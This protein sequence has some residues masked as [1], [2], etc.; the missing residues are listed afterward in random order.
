MQLL[1]VWVIRESPKPDV[2][3]ADQNRREWLGRQARLAIYRPVAGDVA[4]G[5]AGQSSACSLTLVQVSPPQRNPITHPST[6]RLVDDSN[7]TLAL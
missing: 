4:G 7:F 2:P 3:Q 1:S 6:R 5:A